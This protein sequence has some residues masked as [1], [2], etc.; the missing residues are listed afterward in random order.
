MNTSAA[1]K[2]ISECAIF[3]LK[4][5][6]C[7]LIDQGGVG[8]FNRPSPMFLEHYDEGSLQLYAVETFKPAFSRDRSDFRLEPSSTNI[9]TH[10]VDPSKNVWNK[11][12]RVQVYPN[13]IELPNGDY[14]GCRVQFSAGNGNGN[15]IKRT[16]TLE[17]GQYYTFS[18]ILRAVDSSFGATDYIRLT[19]G[20]AEPVEIKLSEL[21]ATPNR[22]VLDPLIRT[23]KTAGSQPTSPGNSHQ[24][25]N[26]A[27]QSVAQ[28]QVVLTIP[29]GYS[30]ES[31]SLKGGQ[32]VIGSKT[33]LIESNTAS[34]SGGISSVV[35]S[36][37]TLI[38]DSVTTNSRAQITNAPTQS[39]TFEMYCESSSSIDW[40]GFQLEPGQF[41]TSMIYQGANVKS[42]A[43]SI[44]SFRR[45]PI[46]GMKTLGLW[47]SLNEI[48]GD[49][50][51]FDMKNL[52]LEVIE[53][54]LRLTIDSIVVSV[55]TPLASGRNE[56]FIQILETQ[57]SASIY[58]NEILK[59]KATIAGF[60]GDRN[61]SLDMTST[62]IRV[63]DEF[64]V[65]DT[66][67]LE[68]QVAVNEAAKGDILKIFQAESLV[69]A[70]LISRP[71]PLIVMPPVTIP[72]KAS[73][74]G[75][76]AM[77]S[78]N[79]STGTIVL[80]NSVG[81]VPGLIVSFYRDGV[82]I[83]E[84]TIKTV[85][86]N[87]I[88]IVDVNIGITEQDMIAYGVNRLPAYASVRF[89]VDPI[90][91]QRIQTI[92]GNILSVSSVLSF[93]LGRAI[94]RTEANQDVAEQL[95]TAIDV[96]QNLITLDSVAG[97]TTGC[98]IFQPANELI[99]DPDNYQVLSLDQ[100]VGVTPAKLGSKY[101]NGVRY[102]NH[103]PYA[104]TITPAIRVYL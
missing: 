4:G 89:P 30:V 17:A 94:I 34:V 97:I 85:V 21:N 32:L 100:V 14:T 61:G 66:P 91:A 83:R 65:L 78:I 47:C 60:R 39:V 26:Y 41:R 96:T 53:N 33:Y 98:I 9:L 87:T 23:F 20:V 101:R 57:S 93:F 29:A 69:S 70:K 50:L 11:G 84:S 58:V 5:S 43:G 80:E 6:L 40:G 36:P 92:S 90:D 19:G 42:R 67:L 13:M 104:V 44:L 28:D 35:V 73:P 49:G 56:I 82:I 72:A 81:F 15:L 31:Q 7:D 54:R 86:G 3:A 38:S 75:M 51:I 79:N 24:I 71:A 10:N 1:T 48:I 59:S 76:T 12:A 64:I 55:A 8:N 102:E 68:G 63:W 103:N 45:S 16:I 18:G 27:I 37:P 77:T 99:I 52:R 46:R 62:G 74:Q 22:Y 2:T 95:I 25:E 88:T